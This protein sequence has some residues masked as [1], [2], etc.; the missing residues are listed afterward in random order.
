MTDTLRP[1]RVA[2]I[3]VP[4][5]SIPSAD[6]WGIGEIGDLPHLAQWCREAGCGLLQLLPVNEMPLHEASP[7]S[8]LSAMAIDPQFISIAQVPEF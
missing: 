5:F 4:L 1:R 7:Y 6:S 2:G 3:L 8:S